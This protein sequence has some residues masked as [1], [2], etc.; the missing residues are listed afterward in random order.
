MI[1]QE[2]AIKGVKASIGE[3]AIT[4]VMYADISSYFP[5]QLEGMQQKSMNAWINI[6]AG[7]G[8]S[9]IEI[10]L[11]FSSPSLPIV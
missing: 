8:R 10:N 6:A 9:L 7:Q 4:H 1:D 5:R 11:V 2:P 3:P